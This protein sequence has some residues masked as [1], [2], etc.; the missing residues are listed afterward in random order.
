MK[1]LLSVIIALFLC[2]CFSAQ[3]QDRVAVLKFSNLDGKEEM[4]KYCL[5][6]QDSLIAHFIAEDPDE[7]NYQ[8]VPAD[9]I[10]YKLDQIGTNPRKPSYQDDLWGVIEALGCKRAVMGEIL[11]NGDKMVVNVSVYDVEMRLPL[12]DHKI[13]NLFATPERLPSLFPRISK[14]LR[15]GVLGN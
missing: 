5:M 9:S 14:K 10:Q 8:I 2:S 3:A 7:L 4:D 6:F 12:P 1:H 15:P 11:M 13:R